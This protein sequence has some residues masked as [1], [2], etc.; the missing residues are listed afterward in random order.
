MNRVASTLM[1]F[2]ASRLVL[3]EEEITAPLP[4]GMSVAWA[5]DGAYRETTP[6]LEKIC[7][8]VLSWRRLGCRRPRSISVR[9][10]P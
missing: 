2:A 10:F 4:A 6:T 7:I 3:A 9:T 8:R 5:L 1:F